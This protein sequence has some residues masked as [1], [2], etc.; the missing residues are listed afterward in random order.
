MST[1]IE[2]YI[3]YANGASHCTQN[4]SSATW[5]IFAPNGELVS[6][7]GICIGHSTNNIF[8]YSAVLELLSDAISHGICHIVIRLDSQLVVLQLDNIYSVRNPAILRIVLRVCL[9][10]THFDFIRYEHISR[11]LNTLVDTLAIFF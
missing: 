11:N 7:Q 5:A 2:Q 1:S 6:M 4:L 10:E 8:E 3:S 9:L